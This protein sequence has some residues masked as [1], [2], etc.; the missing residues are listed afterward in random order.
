M[1]VQSPIQG[2]RP[3]PAGAVAWLPTRVWRPL[4]VLR[5]QRAPSA[6]GRAGNDLWAL[7]LSLPGALRGPTLGRPGSSCFLAKMSVTPRAFGL[8]SPVFPRHGL[9]L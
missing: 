1:C 9:L 2:P 6:V 3:A 7:G 4:A 5:G 8:G